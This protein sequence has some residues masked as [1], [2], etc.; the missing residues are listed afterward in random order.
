MAS[1]DPPATPSAS[2]PAD[3]AIVIFGAAVRPG[4]EPS[5][6]MRRRVQAAVGFGSGF[7][8]ALYVPTGGVGRYGPSEASLM[9][10]LLRRAGVPGTQIVPEEAGTDTLSSVRAAADLLRARGHAGPVY[11]ATSAYHL[12]RCV[13]LLRLAGLS[14]HACPPPPG[15]ASRS[16]RKRWYWRLRE[17]PALPWDA[18][19]MLAERFRR[20]R[21]A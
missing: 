13:L 11:A 18:A 4:G 8:D 14:A 3:A 9:A 20:R 2:V 17:L 16:F 5:G 19:L 21:G 12:P 7:R 6:T 1:G 15:P 10:D